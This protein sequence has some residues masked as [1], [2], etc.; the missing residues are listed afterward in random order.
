MSEIF[1]STN[2]IEAV[3]Y[4]LMG[5]VVL[6][7]LGLLIHYLDLLLTGA[8]AKA[9]NNT[10]A[11]IFRNY[12]TYPGTVHH[13]LAHAL[14][15]FIT[16]AKVLRINLIPRGNRLGSVEFETRGNIFMKAVQ[17]SLSAVAPVICGA[18]SMFLM[19][20][21]ILPNCSIAWHYL[22]FIYIFISIFF[23]MTMSTQDIRNFLKGF[24][25]CMLILFVIFLFVKPDF[26][27]ILQ[28]LQAM[29]A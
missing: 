8:I 17:L 11:F 19:I 26:Y 22:L 9:T 2:I 6:V 5:P 24:P 16:G 7:F 4:A 14:F 13:E 3:V 10:V 1:S 27:G 21:F 23:H 20:Y 29:R 15:A 28:R 12:L 18:V 25:V